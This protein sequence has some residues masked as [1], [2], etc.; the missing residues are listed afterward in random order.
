[1]GKAISVNFF[2]LL[3]VGLL[4]VQPGITYAQKAPQLP[5]QIVMGGPISLS[6]PYSK[7]GSQGHSGVSRWRKNGS[8]KSTAA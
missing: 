8:T 2:A 6:G 4:L 7:E 3:I 5:A 1:M